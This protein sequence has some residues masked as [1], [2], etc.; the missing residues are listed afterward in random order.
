LHRNAADKEKPP[1]DFSGGGSYRGCHFWRNQLVKEGN[2][3]YRARILDEGS[4]SPS[5]ATR[6]RETQAVRHVLALK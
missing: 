6:K 3:L 4:G 5:V 2:A 1:Q